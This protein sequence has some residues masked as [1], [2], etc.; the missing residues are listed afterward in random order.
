MRKKISFALKILVVLTSLGGVF[1]SF[2]SAVKD[3]YHSWADRFL[4]FTGQSNLWLGFTFLAIIIHSF[5]RGVKKEI[6]KKRLYT[7]KYIFTVCITVTCIVFCVF[8]APFAPAEYHLWNFSSFLTHIFSPAFAIADFFVDEYSM[9]LTKKQALLT[10][11]PPFIYTMAVVLLA[12]FHADFGRGDPYPY[13]FMNI[14]SPSGFF[15]FSNVAP[16]F[17]GTF[18]WILALAAMVFGIA[19]LYA[20]FKNPTKKRSKTDNV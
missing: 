8:L 16:Y 9:R 5:T 6:R 3:G 4:Y 15:G 7:L 20:R 12:A 2:F 1:I 10:T 18:Y 17:A 14:Y 19:L 13:Y 11:V